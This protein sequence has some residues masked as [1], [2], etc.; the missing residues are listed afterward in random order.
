MAGNKTKPERYLYMLNDEVDLFIK[1]AY[2]VTP[3]SGLLFSITLEGGLRISETLAIRVKDIM[4]EDNKII[5]WSLK[6]SKHKKEY[7]LFPSR[8]IRICRTIIKYYSLEQE[9]RIFP[10]TRQYAWQLF[11]KICRKAGLSSKYS[12]HALRHNHGMVIAEITKG[13][14]V[15]IAKRLR[16]SSLAYVGMYTHL[17][18][19]M[20]EEIVKGIEKIRKKKK[21]GDSIE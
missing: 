9:N 21:G 8:V 18:D 19:E 4:F 16:H 13:D 15:K 6:R 17:T 14:P 12:P 3:K 11:K 2:S 5:I 10:Y 7:L 1:A 20:Q